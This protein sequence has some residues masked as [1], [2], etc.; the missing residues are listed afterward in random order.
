MARH[1]TESKLVIASHNPGKVREIDALLAPFGVEVVSAAALGLPE[2]V[3]DG[4]S[5]VA[6]AEIKALAAARAAGLP[7]LADDSGLAV[8]ALGGEPG[9]HSARWAGETK[10]FG[11]AMA[12]V[13]HR[14][15]ASG[16]PGDTRAHFVC[17]LSLCWPQTDGTPAHLE[18]FE[19]SVHG[20]LIWPPRGNNGFGYD[21]MFVP[22]GYA[23]T[24]GE[25]DPGEKHAISHRAQAFRLLV[26]ACFA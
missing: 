19:G 17:A 5:F 23:I 7:A 2:P 9:I 16:T 20:H 10:D 13:W 21:P 18:T 8:A 15:Q 1:F 4:A 26:A 22:D 11:Q 25:F 6:N 24:F 12:E 14:L 3:E